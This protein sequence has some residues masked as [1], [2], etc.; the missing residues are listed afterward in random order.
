MLQVA[1]S[2]SLRGAQGSSVYALPSAGH[3]RAT[4]PLQVFVPGLHVPVHSPAPVQT[5]GQTRSRT[6]TPELLHVSRVWS[7]AQCAVSG[8]QLPVQLPVVA[9]QALLVQ[10][11]PLRQLPLSSQLR[12]V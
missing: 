1:V 5:L 2:P 11:V 10:V 3:V 6:H 12:G 8:K 4:T 9:L 7:A